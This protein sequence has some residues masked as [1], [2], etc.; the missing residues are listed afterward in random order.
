MHGIPEQDSYNIHAHTFMHRHTNSLT[1]NFAYVGSGNK[2]NSAMT[3]IY[4]QVITFIFNHYD[5]WCPKYN[6]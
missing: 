6:E 2:I 4:R 5:N 1:V 3:G